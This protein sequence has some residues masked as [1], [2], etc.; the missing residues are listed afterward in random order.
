MNV[1]PSSLRSPAPEGAARQR[2]GEAGSAAVAWSSS[3]ASYLERRAE[4]EHY[5]DRT[6]AETW[7]RLTSDAP[8]SRIR[9]TVRAGRDRMR[10][11]LLSWLRADMSGTRVLDAGC[12]T[13]ALAVELARR[14]ATVLAIDLSPQLVDVARLRAAELRAKAPWRGHIEFTHGDM[15]DEALGAF[16]HVVAMDS[17]IHYR[18]ADAVKVL[19]TLAPRVAGRTGSMVFTFAPATRALRAMH[20]VGRLFPRGDRA[21][22]IVPV[23]EAELRR[24]LARHAALQG[25]QLARSQRVAS[26]FYTSQAFELVAPR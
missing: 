3:D 21:P 13:G 15:G 9:E 12:G 1:P 23:A 16:D 5:F 4:I 20:A 8:V 17:L 26:G 19:A 22:A 7:A 10:D 18:T 2:P 11:T 25:W 6:A 24:E 14:G